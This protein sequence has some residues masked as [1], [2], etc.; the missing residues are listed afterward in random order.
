MFPSAKLSKLKQYRMAL[1]HLFSP[2]NDIVVTLSKKISV[3][4]DT[5]IIRNKESP[6]G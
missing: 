5:D 1:S 6:S 2:N 4:G 3:R